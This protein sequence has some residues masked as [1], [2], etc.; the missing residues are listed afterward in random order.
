MERNFGPYTLIHQIAVGGM[1]EIHLARTEG[2]AGFEKYVA[3][4]MIHPNFS[5]DQQFVQ[6][7]IDEAKI[8][9]QLAHVN[10][11]QTFDLGR[12]GNTYYITMEFVEGC[13]LYKLL[14]EG[15]ELE[16]DTPIDVAAHI[17]KEAATG[18]DYAHRKRD[19]MGQPLKIIHR[20]VSPQ[21]LLVSSMGEVKVIDFGIAKATMRAQETQAG[22]IKGKYYYMSP[23]QAWGEHLD[24]RTDIFSAG[25]ILYELLT[26]QMLYLE[27]D[28]HVLLERIREAKID[29]P[30]TLRRDIPPELED[31]VMR[32]L[33]KHPNDRFSTGAEMAQA[34]ERFLRIHSP[35]CGANTVTEWTGRVLGD[36]DAEPFVEDEPSMDERDMRALTQGIGSEQLLHTGDDFNDENSI[37]FRVSDVDERMRATEDENDDLEE[38][39][40]ID[41]ETGVVDTGKRDV[42]DETQALTNRAPILGDNTPL[43]ELYPAEGGEGEDRTVVSGPPGF[44]A[45][46]PGMGTMGSKPDI[47]APRPHNPAPAPPKPTLGARAGKPPIVRHQ[48]DVV[49]FD[50]EQTLA[51]DSNSNLSMQAAQRKQPPATTARSGKDSS[52]E[53]TGEDEPTMAVQPGPYR[54]S[55]VLNTSNPKPAVSVLKTP[56]KSRRTPPK[57]VP[58]QGQQQT[59]APNSVL[60]YLVTNSGS[61]AQVALSPNLGSAPQAANVRVPLQQHPAPQHPAPGAYG[62]QQGQSHPGQ[63]HPAMSQP[64]SQPGAQQGYQQQAEQ[65][66]YG[67]QPRIP[68]P[69]MQQQGLPAPYMQQQGLPAPYM[70]QQGGFPQVSGLVPDAR[71]AAYEVDELP[72]AYIL[73]NRQS[74]AQWLVSLLG[75]AV[76]TVGAAAAA[77]FLLTHKDESDAQPATLMVVSTPEGASVIVNGSLL[78]GKTPTSYSNANVGDTLKVVVDLRG[79]RKWETDT[80]IKTP[81]DKLIARLDPILVNLTVTSVPPGAEIYLNGNASAAGRT[82]KTF[83][84][85]DPMTAT[86]IVLK[87]NGFRAERRNLDWTKDTKKEV[88]FLLK[89]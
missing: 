17:V 85:I 52:A 4:K 46:M 58:A 11:A 5:E 18:L 25:I 13:D 74:K 20:D 59:Q 8:T 10:I 66:Q 69:Y 72:D 12:V 55:N 7:L 36:P 23:E 64:Y 62:Q 65:Q 21:N 6:M 1:A 67:Q 78:T 16:I 70:Q 73:T 89:P 82:P 77:Y 83:S 40:D 45:G 9:V 81:D 42:S 35:V 29:P 63:Q 47:A 37:I 88:P 2:I 87:K 50:S 34:L 48:K 86:S 43:P 38:D 51:H 31:I 57:G 60:S 49:D 61:R 3:I 44:G 84:D 79:H 22:V 24:A 54:K 27:E 56:R 19:V 33:Q 53:V 26:G 75:F 41:Q 14:R 30:S 76:L 68:A 15:S 39:R 71:M 32:A 28:T 80:V